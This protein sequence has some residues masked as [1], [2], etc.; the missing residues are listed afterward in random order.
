MNVAFPN[1]LTPLNLPEGETL[2][3]GS[4]HHQR[5][6]PLPDSSGGWGRSK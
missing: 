1:H 6:T 4:N 3:S 5:N 2:D